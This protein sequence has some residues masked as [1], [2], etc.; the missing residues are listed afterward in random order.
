MN[1]NQKIDDHFKN[2]SKEEFESNLKDAGYGVIQPASKLGYE[3]SES[4][5]RKNGNENTGHNSN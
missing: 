1:L 3:L 4:V 5:E 2:I